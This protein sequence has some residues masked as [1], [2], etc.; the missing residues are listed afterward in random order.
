MIGLDTNVIVRYLTQDDPAQSK[1]ANELI[2]NTLTP[3]QPGFITLISL[4]ELAWVLESCYEQSRENV[5]EALNALLTPRQ[6]MIENAEMVHLAL[7]RFSGG[8][9]F[10]DALIA[11][12]SEF[13]GCDLVKTFDKK[14][15]RVGMTLL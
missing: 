2:D 4:I 5:H 7:K 15:V 9:D 1:K 14:A 12:I 6:L 11:V 10:S 13:N 8:G 3:A